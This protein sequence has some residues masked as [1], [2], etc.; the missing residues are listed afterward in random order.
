MF[1]RVLCQLQSQRAVCFSRELNSLRE[2]QSV[3]V[4][5]GSS[6]LDSELEQSEPEEERGAGFGDDRK[7]GQVVVLRIGSSGRVLARTSDRLRY[8]K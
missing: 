4:G 6:C 2:S 5:D 1:V 7:T 8:V 3:L